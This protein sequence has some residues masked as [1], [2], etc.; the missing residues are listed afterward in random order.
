MPMLSLAV[1]PSLSVM[2]RP[3]C[4]SCPARSFTVTARPPPNGCR[5][6]SGGVPRL[7]SQLKASSS[8][9]WSG[10]RTVPTAG[11]QDWSWG[12]TR[13]YDDKLT[14]AFEEGWAGLYLHTAQPV[15]GHAQ[16]AI[17]ISLALDLLVLCGAS[18]GGSVPVSTVAHVELSVDLA[19]CGGADG[20]PRVI[21]Q[22]GT[23]RTQPPFV[24][25]ALELRGPAGTLTLLVSEA[26]AIG[27][28]FD[29]VLAWAEANGGPPVFVGE[30][31]AYGAADFGARVPWTRAVRDAAE[32]RGFGWAYWEFGAG[33]GAYDPVVGR[34]QPELLDALVGE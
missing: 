20:V 2:V 7:A 5:T 32:A 21:A 29:L 22:N 1:A 25:V 6:T 19:A 34:W 16:L 17:R 28:A 31:A 14:V 33:F 27:A 13:D 10:T 3:T 11:W 18:D 24:V 30:F 12:T 26:E 15:T 8:S 4:Q 9:A 23:D